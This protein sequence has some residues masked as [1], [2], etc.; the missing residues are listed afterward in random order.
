MEYQLC[1][2]YLVLRSAAQIWHSKYN[3]YC[4]QRQSLGQVQGV[5]GDGRESGAGVREGEWSDEKE[6]ESSSCEESA[7]RG[8]LWR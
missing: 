1:L 3:R 6:R 7:G 5:G 2:E 8:V 4:A